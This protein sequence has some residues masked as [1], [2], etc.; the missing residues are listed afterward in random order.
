M[1]VPTFLGGNF[2][3]KAR[4]WTG[5]PRDPRGDQLEEMMAAYN[6]VV[7]NEPGVHTYAKEIARSVFDLLFASLE[8][9]KNISSWEVLDAVTQPSP[10]C[11]DET[12]REEKP[13]EKV[14]NKRWMI[15][16]KD[17]PQQIPTTN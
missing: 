5:G 4:A 15:T 14:Q 13:T 3:A 2:N 1:E 7:A 11:I 8:V 9:T 16:S 10:I 6:L 12:P 17:E